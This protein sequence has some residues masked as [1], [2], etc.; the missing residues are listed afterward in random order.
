[1][2]LLGSLAG[3]Q[4]ADPDI[5]STALDGAG[6]SLDMAGGLL[7]LA[8]SVS[9]LA[10]SASVISTGLLADRFFSPRTAAPSPGR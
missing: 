7:A 3:V 10:L 1:M 8:A 2:P 6:R 4:G 9:T 5:A